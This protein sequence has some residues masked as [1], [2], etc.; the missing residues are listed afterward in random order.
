MGKFCKKT[1][2]LEAFFSTDSDFK[3][4]IERLKRLLQGTKDTWFESKTRYNK[5]PEFQKKFVDVN[6]EP[7]W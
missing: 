1:T 6:S 3:N 2:F 4:Y 5:F 7:L